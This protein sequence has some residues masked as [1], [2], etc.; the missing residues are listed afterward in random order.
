VRKEMKKKMK[1]VII[2]GKMKVS[3]QKKI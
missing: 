3:P 2:K 1:R